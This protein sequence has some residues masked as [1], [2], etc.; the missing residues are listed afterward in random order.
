MVVSCAAYNCTESKQKGS[1]SDVS[2]HR[3]PLRNPEQLKKWIHEMKRKDFVPNQHSRICSKHFELSCFVVRPG[4]QGRRLYDHAVPTIFDFDKPYFQ[5]TKPKRKAPKKREFV[6]P[7][8]EV[9]DD[10][11]LPSP[12]KGC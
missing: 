4:K 3:F 10:D 9:I 5:K 8:A 1:S 12:S 2:F 11:V 7:V 6:E